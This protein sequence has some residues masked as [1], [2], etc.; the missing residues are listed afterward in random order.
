MAPISD[1]DMHILH[2]YTWAIIKILDENPTLL[3]RVLVAYVISALCQTKR[4]G[5]ASL[6]VGKR[7]TLRYAI[8]SI[9]QFLEMALLH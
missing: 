2:S 8:N 1:S 9:T 3:K 6:E 7:D 5:T 4:L